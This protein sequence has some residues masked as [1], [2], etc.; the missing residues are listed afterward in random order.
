MVKAVYCF[1]ASSMAICQK[2]AFRSKQEKYPA[3]T[4]LSVA[5]L[6]MWQQY[7]ESFLVLAFSLQKLMQKHSPPSFLHTI[8]T[9]LH[10]G[11][12]LGWIVPTSRI[13]FTCVYGFHPPLEGGILQNLS[14]KAHHQWPCSHVL[15]R[16]YNPALLVQ[17]KRCH[18]TQPTGFGQLLNFPQTTPPSQIDPA[19][20]VSSLL[21][22]VNWHPHLLATLDPV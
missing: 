11:L 8:T 4:R 9:A 16:P 13:S 2:P 19:V 5:T 6:D 17:G 15:P 20:G 7:N 3:P 14:L 10:H 18:D 12:W 22:P 21:P 1:E